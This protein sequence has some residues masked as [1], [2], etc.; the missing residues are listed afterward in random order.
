M[1]I[2]DQSRVSFRKDSHV[3]QLEW[4]LSRASAAMSI[5]LDGRSDQRYWDTITI[6]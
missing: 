2:A 4:W 1:L 5:D 6:L 3:P